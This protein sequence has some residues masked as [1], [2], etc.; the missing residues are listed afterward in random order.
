[1]N[2]RWAKVEVYTST[3]YHVFFDT[4]D[5][6]L[7]VQFGCKVSRLQHNRWKCVPGRKDCSSTCSV[8]RKLWGYPLVWAADITKSW[9]LKQSA[10]VSRTDRWSRWLYGRSII[11]ASKQWVICFFFQ[12]LHL[13]AMD[14]IL[15]GLEPPIKP[16][17]VSEYSD[18]QLLRVWLNKL[19]EASNAIESTLSLSSQQPIALRAR[20]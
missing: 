3:S 8:C 1:M 20:W 5:T 13:Y 18:D 6:R 7:S 19:R 12:M 14:K 15:S 10:P 4:A 17:R 11:L 2:T 16:K 9:D